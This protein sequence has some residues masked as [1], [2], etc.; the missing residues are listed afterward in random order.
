[1]VAVGVRLGGIRG[2]TRF[3]GNGEQ[4]LASF[5]CLHCAGGRVARQGVARATGCAAG[6]AALLMRHLRNA[7][8]R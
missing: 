3:G 4:L 1:M 2:I 6:P 5:L 7:A 8:L